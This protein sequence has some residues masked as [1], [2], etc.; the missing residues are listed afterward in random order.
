MTAT[1][2][3]GMTNT[4]LEG[5][6]ERTFKEERK[7][8]RTIQGR[9]EGIDGRNSQGRKEG[10][11]AQTTTTHTCGTQRTWK[12]GKKEDEVEGREEGYQGRKEGYQGRKEGYQGRKEGYQG[13]KEGYQGRVSR[14]EGRKEGLVPAQHM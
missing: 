1:T 11:R 2:T 5:R 14:K 4:N 8:G 10:R 9:K 6:K 13:R 7:E 3:V 12:E